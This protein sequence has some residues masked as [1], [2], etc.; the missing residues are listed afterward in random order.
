VKTIIKLI[1]TGGELDRVVLDYDEADTQ[2]IATATIDLIRRTG[3]SLHEG[4]SITITKE[5]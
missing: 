3:L 5:T 2:T 4:D 1:G